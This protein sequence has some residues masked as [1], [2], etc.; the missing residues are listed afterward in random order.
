M[1]NVR[2]LAKVYFTCYFVFHVT[3][4]S[5]KAPESTGTSRPLTNKIKQLLVPRY[6]VLYYKGH[7]PVIF[8][9]GM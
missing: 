4:Y 1:S 3:L 8:S 5:M 6:K 2:F 9:N 7:F